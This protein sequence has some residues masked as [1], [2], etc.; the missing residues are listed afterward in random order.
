M[1]LVV[2]LYGVYLT[3]L[4]P[5]LQHRSLDDFMSTQLPDTLH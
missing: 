4:L 3:E 1:L 5:Y 2:L